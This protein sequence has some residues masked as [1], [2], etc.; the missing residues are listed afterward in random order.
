MKVRD[1]EKLSITEID[2]ML[3]ARRDSENYSKSMEF[4]KRRKA[5]AE[6]RKK[7][8]EKIGTILGYIVLVA[9]SFTLSVIGV[10]IKHYFNITGEF[11]RCY[12][13]FM[14]LA[15]IVLTY[16]LGCG[17]ARVIVFILKKNKKSK[18][19]RNC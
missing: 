13:V 9:I 17:L 2:T 16:T 3:E 11:A 12:F 5:R 19:A 15:N 4:A 7:R 10:S 6:K 14:I 1:T 18:N 8:D